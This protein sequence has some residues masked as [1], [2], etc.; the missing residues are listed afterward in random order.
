MSVPSV[1]IS[2]Y[3]RQER[4][5]VSCMEEGCNSSYIIRVIAFNALTTHNIVHSMNHILSVPCTRISAVTGVVPRRLGVAVSGT[6]KVGPRF[7]GT[8]RRRSSVRHLVSLTGHLR[9]LPERASVRTTNIIVDRGSMSRCMPLSETRSNSVIARFAVAALRR[10]KLLGVSFLNLHAL[11]IV[12]GTI[13]VIRGDANVLL[14]VRGVSCGSGGMLSSLKAKHASNIFRLRDTKVGDFVGRLGPRDLRSIVTKVSL[15]HPNPVSF[16][17]RCVHKGGHPSAVHCSYPRVRP[18]LG[19]ACNYVMCRRRIV[20]VIHRLTNCALKQDSLIHHTV[21]GGGTSIVTGRHRGFICK[22]I[23][24]KMPKYVTGNV[25][26]RVTGGVCSR[27]ASFTGCTFGGSRTTTCTIISCRATCL[28]CCCPMRFVTTLVASIIRVPGG[29]TRCVSMYHRVKVQV[30]P[31]SVGRNICNFSISGNSVHCTLSTVG[32]VNHPMVRKVIQRHRR[33]K[34]CAS[35]GAFVRQGVSRV[36]GEI[37]RGLVGT[38]TLSYLRKGQ[39]RGVAICAR[40]V[41]DVGRSGGRAVTKR[42]DLFSVT[43]RRSG[44]RFRVHVPRTTRCPGRAV[45]AFRGRILN[46]CLD[47]RPLRHCQ[48]V[49]RGVVSTGASSFR[50][51][52]RAKVPRICSGRGI[53]I[54]KVVASGAVGCAGGGGMVTFLAIRSLMNAIRIIMF[55]HS[56]RGYR[57]FLGRS[58][59]LFVRKEMSTRSSGTDGLVLRGIHLF[60]SVPERL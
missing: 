56:C 31:P 54:N 5:I 59:Q 11:A 21:S 42:L 7:H 14:S 13:G 1:S 17:P 48:G 24:R 50:P 57:V 35:L 33:R 26:R 25:S 43:P 45:L 40:V 39:G 51:S 36:G 52:S 3:F 6:L 37:I 15:C 30:L 49:V 27:V 20:R 46:V 29:I 10:L 32:D 34:R 2:F 22:G 8:C 9:K 53:V 18:V 28:G 38:K 23:R 58:T 19:P 55:P 16:V 12:R 4:R 60:S 47:N 44:G 41:S